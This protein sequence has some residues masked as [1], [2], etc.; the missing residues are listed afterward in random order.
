MKIESIDIERSGTLWSAK[1]VVS[2]PAGRTTGTVDHN[3]PQQAAI[4]ATA[5]AINE[6]KEHLLRSV[7]V[8]PGVTF[9]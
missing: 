6:H 2:G 5:D 8:T 7:K 9:A 3:D 1:A 4:R